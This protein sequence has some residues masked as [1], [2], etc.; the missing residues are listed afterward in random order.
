MPKQQILT[1]NSFGVFAF[2]LLSRVLLLCWQHT[3]GYWG[4]FKV[5]VFKPEQC[6]K[7]KYKQTDATETEGHLSLKPTL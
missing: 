3:P 1:T 2:S 6:H 5:F 7:H 4:S